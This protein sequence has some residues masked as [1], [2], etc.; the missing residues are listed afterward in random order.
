MK[1]TQQPHDA[2]QSIGLDNVARALL[3]F[4]GLQRCINELSVT[5]L[6]STNM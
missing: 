3:E 2:G 4:G 5:G 1:A 6:T